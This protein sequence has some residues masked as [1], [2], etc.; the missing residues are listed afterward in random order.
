MGCHTVAFPTA[1]L[2]ADEGETSLYERRFIVDDYLHAIEYADE[3]SCHKNQACLLLSVTC[4]PQY[5][6]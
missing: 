3:S 4:H 1:E 6:H 2:H 5:L